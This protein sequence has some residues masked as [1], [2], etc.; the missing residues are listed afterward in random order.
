MGGPL[1]RSTATWKWD[2][3]LVRRDRDG[4]RLWLIDWELAA[5]GDPLWDLAAV[6][7]GLVT[8]SLPS[9]MA[10][11]ASPRSGRS[12]AWRSPRTEPHRRA[13]SGFFHFVAARLVQVTVQLAGMTGS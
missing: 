13:G 1:P 7:E 12:R 4:L 5:W 11:R 9:P 3:V 6:L 10:R 8:T 2:N